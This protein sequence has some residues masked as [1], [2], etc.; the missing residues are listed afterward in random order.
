VK[1]VQWIAECLLRDTIRGSFVPNEVLQQMR[2]YFRRYR[3]L[4]K[5]RVRAEQ[6]I[7]QSFAT[8]QYPL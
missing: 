2:Q 3:Y 4:T 1:D 5:N 7:G 8:L 6:R